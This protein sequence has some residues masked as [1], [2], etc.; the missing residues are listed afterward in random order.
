MRSWGGA[1]G[2]VISSVFFPPVTPKSGRDTLF[3]GICH[4]HFRSV[5]GTFPK[6]V[7]GQHQLVTAIFSK[8][9]TG[10]VANVTG[11]LN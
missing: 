7:T 6:S 10:N 11:N 4:G 9:V 5:T 3:G 2:T 1:V 8:I